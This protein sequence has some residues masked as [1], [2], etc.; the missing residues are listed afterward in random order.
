MQQNFSGVKNTGGTK[1]PNDVNS[2]NSTTITQF[3]LA[4]VIYTSGFLKSCNLTATAKLVLMALIQHYNANN[5]DMFPS[6]K[7]LAQQLGISEKSV[8]RA[9]ANLKDEDLIYYVT[10]RVNRY[11]FTAHF[12]EQIKMSVVNR[13]NVGRDVRQNVGETNKSEKR[14]EK[15]KFLNF[16]SFGLSAEKKFFGNGA[17]APQTST[18]E[19]ALKN[20]LKQTEMQNAEV[21][22]ARRLRGSSG[23]EGEATSPLEWSREDALKWVQSLAPVFRSRGL[24]KT[25]TNMHNYTDEELWGAPK[26]FDE[27]TGL[28]QQSVCATSQ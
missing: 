17:N 19:Q 10:K 9:I 4:K 16:A 14:N 2:W 21:S 1:N 22:Q 5:A 11:R 6:Q 3:E 13:Q 28:Q 18:F 24:A 15:E 20:D 25:L 7:F 12:F 26:E 23:E 27:S 8:E